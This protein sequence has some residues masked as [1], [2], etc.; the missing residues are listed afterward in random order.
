[1]KRSTNEPL[2]DIVMEWKPQVKERPRFVRATGRVYTPAN[3]LEAEG[4]LAAAFKEAAP[5]WE[6]YKET[7]HIEWTFTNTHVGVILRAHNDYTQRKLR[8]DL[9][10]YVKLGSDALNGLL[11]ADDRQ[12]VRNDSIKL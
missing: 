6:P 4:V 10:N 1:M 3:T 11:Y 8:G 12:I 9:D 5:D 2:L 7:C